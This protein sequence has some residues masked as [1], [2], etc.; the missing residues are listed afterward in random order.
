MLLRSSRFPYRN[1]CEAI[2]SYLDRHL[3][4]SAAHG[5]VCYLDSPDSLV[6]V[7]DIVS[8]ANVSVN[9]KTFKLLL[10]MI[11]GNPVNTQIFA[12]RFMAPR[13]DDKNRIILDFSLR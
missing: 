9:L 7:I 1:Q 5:T 8:Q 13:G 3:S 12:P 10:L 4:N 11:L 6:G 2:F